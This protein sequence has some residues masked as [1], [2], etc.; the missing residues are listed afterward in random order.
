MA[1]LTLI[2]G[3]VVSFVFLVGGLALL[4][5][6]VKGSGLLD[7]ESLLDMGLVILLGTPVLRVLVLALG[8]LRA[9]RITFALVAFCILLL[10]GASVAIGLR[11]E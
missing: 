1:R 2:T 8:Y 4:T 7:A 5:G 10:L 6:G 9:R 11:G 3:V